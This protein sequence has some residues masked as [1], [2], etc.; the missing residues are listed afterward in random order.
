[1]KGKKP[2]DAELASIR[3][4]TW[5]ALETCVDAGLVRSIGVSNY[6]IKHLQELMQHARIKPSLLQAEFHPYLTQKEL[7]DYCNSK[8]IMF[9]AYSSLGTSDANLSKNVNFFLVT[10]LRKCLI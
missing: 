7:I 3:A 10:F 5:K 8:S 4:Q 6:T 1:V 2:N 9:Q